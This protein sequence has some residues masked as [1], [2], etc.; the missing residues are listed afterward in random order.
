MDL[1]SIT[2]VPQVGD[3]RASGSPGNHNPQ[4][5]GVLLNGVLQ[6]KH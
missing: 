1:M 6:N 3:N 2:L 5:E 4:R